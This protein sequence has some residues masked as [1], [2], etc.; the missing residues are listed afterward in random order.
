MSSSWQAIKGPLT[1]TSV[2]T[3]ILFITYTSQIFVIWPYLGAATIHSILILVPLNFFVV[4]ALINY[5]LTCKT[6]PG[7]VPTRWIPR[8]QA[9]IEVKKSTH[10]PRFCKTCDNYKP[11]RAHHCSTCNR[12]VLKMDHHCP[13]VNNCVGFANYCHFFRFLIYVDISS[14]YLFILLSC[15]LAQLVRDMRHYDIRPTALE[16]AF[17]SINLI[18]ATTIMIT[19]GILTSYHIYCI[20]TN[21]TTIEGWE[22]GRSLTIK[23][24]G[25]IHNIKCP[26]D[27][28]IYKN[29]QSVLG[30]WPIL[31]L[32]PRS[33]SG[34][35]LDFPINT[36]YVDQDEE[37]IIIEKTFS[38]SVSLNRTASI[39]SQST[40]ATDTPHLSND[41]N[42]LIK[43]DI[44]PL[45]PLKTKPSINTIGS[46][47]IPNTP[48]SVLT[49][50]STVTT[51]VDNYSQ[52]S[53]ANSNKMVIEEPS[54]YSISP[55]HHHR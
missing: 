14:I 7:A 18:L 20:S 26:Y 25:K 31:W 4:M 3:T 29:V 43:V 55:Q 21:T 13:W 49:F 42:E 19:V 41:E 24:M 33:I 51:L 45:K 38:S 8:Q 40:S 48:G 32:V 36:K 17:L 22:K 15:R 54:D 9:F 10:T 27:Q 28:G 44:T 12:C 16:S 47:S 35:G 50:A 2:T 23:G 1:V 30:R 53:T 39:N 37:S 5:F 11:P 34:T 52:K 6:D 46:R